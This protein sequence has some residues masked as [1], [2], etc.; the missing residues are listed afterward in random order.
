MAHAEVPARV[1]VMSPWEYLRSAYEGLY[2]QEPFWNALTEA[3]LVA[4]AERMGFLDSAQGFQR[5]M[6]DG[7]K[8]AS[9]EAFVPVDQ[10]KLDLSNWF[11]MSA[12]KPGDEYHA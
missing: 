8:M 2:N 4:V 6:S 3:D 12:R 5:T 9:P 11:A 7:R 10:G 1:E